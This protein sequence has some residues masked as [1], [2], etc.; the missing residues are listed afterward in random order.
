MPNSYF[1]LHSL[2]SNISFILIPLIS[3][4]LFPYIL[5]LSFHL[6]SR[7][8]FSIQFLKASKSS[9]H[10][11]NGISLSLSNVRTSLLIRI[12]LLSRS[13]LQLHLLLFLFHPNLCRLFFFSFLFY[14]YTTH[15]SLLLSSTFVSLLL[16]LFTIR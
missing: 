3:R 2:Y 11:P 4:P 12:S 16:I 9:L 5:S 15:T 10:F 6:T 14:N 1:S 7:A 13:S 8:L